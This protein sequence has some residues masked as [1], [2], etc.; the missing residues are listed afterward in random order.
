MATVTNE[1]PDELSELVAQA[2]DLPTTVRRQ[3]I[4]RAG[5]LCE[6]CLVEAGVAFFPPLS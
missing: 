6:Y 5:N 3:V 1:V 4:E 2:G